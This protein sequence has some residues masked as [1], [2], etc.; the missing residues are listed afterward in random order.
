L[1]RLDP[2]AAMALR[3]LTER[4]GGRIPPEA[5]DDIV[6][7]FLAGE[8]L[9]T[10]SFPSVFGAELALAA[11]A[12]LAELGGELLVETSRRQRNR[13]LRGSGPNRSDP[14]DVTY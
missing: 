3:R 9:S 12:L 10:R 14:P 13:P 1:S 5:Y 6:V 11:D 4:V 7:D 8:V 2:T